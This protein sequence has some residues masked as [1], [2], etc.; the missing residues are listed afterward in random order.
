VNATLLSYEGTCF[1]GLNID[2]GAVPD[3]SVM[4]ECVR[5]GFSEIL[6]GHVEGST[7]AA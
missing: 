7:P 5:E 4:A 1:I 3:A 6:S 2:T